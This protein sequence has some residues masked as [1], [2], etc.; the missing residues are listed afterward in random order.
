VT[1]PEHLN[2]HLGQIAENMG[3]YP[4]DM[5]V[6]KM[7]AGADDRHKELELLQGSWHEERPWII[8]DEEDQVYTLTSAEALTKIIR[9]LSVTQSE[10]FQYKLE[11]AILQ[12]L[13]IDFHDVWEVAMDRIRTLVQ[14]RPESTVVN[15]DLDW[16]VSE[17]KQK[18]PNLF[19]Q[20][21]QILGEKK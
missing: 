9:L 13:P 18:Y 19:Y 20:L 10:N 6:V 5:T 2:K 21:D 8:I 17:I 15:L 7:S 3:L 14:S 1:Y 4:S 11:K 16:L 12:R